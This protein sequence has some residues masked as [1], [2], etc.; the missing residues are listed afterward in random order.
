MSSKSTAPMTSNKKPT[1]DAADQHKHW[2]DDA[3]HIVTSAIQAKAILAL[4]RLYEGSQ[5]DLPTG[6]LRNALWAAEDLISEIGEAAER[7][8]AETITRCAALDQAQGTKLPG[9]H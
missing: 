5:E 6:S 2:S 9:T 8:A 4:A 7:L 1:R 3:E